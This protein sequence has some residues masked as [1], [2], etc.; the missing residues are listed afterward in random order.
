MSYID[1]RGFDNFQD[2]A[3]QMSYLIEQDVP[4][5]IKF[6]PE[7]DDWRDWAMCVVGGQDRLG[8]D[9]PDP[10]FFDDWRDW[11]RRLFATQDFVG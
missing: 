3:D 4:Q 2:W 7:Y 6:N 8:Q 1:P 9:S 5:F 10:Y 11:A